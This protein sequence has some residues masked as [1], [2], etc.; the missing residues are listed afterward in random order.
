MAP[1]LEVMFTIIKVPLSSH[2]S[3]PVVC[4]SSCRHPA[5]YVH[6]YVQGSWSRKLKGR[7]IEKNLG[8]QTRE[9]RALLEK[10]QK[11]NVHAEKTFLREEL[12]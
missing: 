4:P 7:Y 9:P 11:Q 5:E 10:T 3:R 8:V 1:L 6:V 12:K 2:L